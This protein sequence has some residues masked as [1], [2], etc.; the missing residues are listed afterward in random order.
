MRGVPPHVCCVRA[1]AGGGM[2][3]VWHLDVFF[4]SQGPVSIQC[5]QHRKVRY[6]L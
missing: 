6:R 1:R 3:F 5:R 4:P 2:G